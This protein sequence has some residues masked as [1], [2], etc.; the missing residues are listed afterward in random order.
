MPA[1]FD[2][3]KCTGCGLCAQLCPGD[4]IRMVDEQGGKR[5]RNIYP[6][7]CW[8]CASCR[9]DCPEQAITIRFF[10]DMLAI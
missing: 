8:H 7:E 2:L 10:P 1:V 9:Q 6:L 3:E 5:P 4:V